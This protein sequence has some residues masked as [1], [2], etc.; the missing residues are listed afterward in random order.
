MLR[1]E[2]ALVPWIKHVIMPI[3]A[4][5]NAGVI[6]GG[7][8]AL[9][10]LVS[11]ISGGVICGLA[12]GKPIGIVGF[13]WLAIRL[14]LAS[15]PGGVVWRQIIGVGVLAGIGFTMSLFIAG[16]AFGSTAELD[17]A[18]VGILAASVA[19]G[20]TGMLI[21]VKKRPREEAPR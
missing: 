12:L 2:H 13:S 11:P 5:A 8:D 20:S 16:L 9:A 10:A 14:R 18:K 1:F 7:G 3:F 15:L 4:L 21:L 6:F 17:T 19:A